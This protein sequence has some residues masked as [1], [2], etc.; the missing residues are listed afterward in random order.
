MFRFNNPDALLV[1][2]LVG[3]GVRHAARASSPRTEERGHPVRG[4]RSAAP[5]SA[6]PS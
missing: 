6:S 5:W 4:S 1:L 2:L 3:V